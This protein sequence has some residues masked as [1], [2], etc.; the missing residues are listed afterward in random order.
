MGAVDVE[1]VAAA[2]SVDEV[3]AGCRLAGVAELVAVADDDV[4]AA[5]LLLDD[6]T[7]AVV[8]ALFLPN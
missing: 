6:A 1:L 2:A 5:S 4:D 7:A 8:S 3:V